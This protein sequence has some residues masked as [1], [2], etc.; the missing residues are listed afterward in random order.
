MI[1]SP[2]TSVTRGAGH[3]P[4]SRRSFIGGGSGAG[5]AGA[6][7]GVRRCPEDATR[8]GGLGRVWAPS[9]VTRKLP[10]DTFRS[11]LCDCVCQS[12]S[13]PAT[14]GP[15]PFPHADL[16]SF[17]VSGLSVS[18][19]LQTLFRIILPPGAA[20][21]EPS[22]NPRPVLNNQSNSETHAVSTWESFQ[23]WT[24]LRCPS[25]L[26]P[27]FQDTV[28][29]YPLMNF[30]KNYGQRRGQEPWL[31]TMGHS[32]PVFSPHL[33]RAQGSRVQNEDILWHA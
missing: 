5:K 14:S 27:K 31:Q 29:F 33:V 1:C 21:R 9:P 28:L 26:Q 8:P 18:A 22:P 13:L 11:L 6:Q 3:S 16:T 17:P 12:L 23:N 10:P 7:L 32:L 15:D 20:T 2:A 25:F 24:G 4:R 19:L 30:H